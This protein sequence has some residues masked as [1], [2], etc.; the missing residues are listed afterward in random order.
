MPK[1]EQFFEHAN[2]AFHGL[3]TLDPNYFQ[4]SK[5]EK[6][7]V[8]KN[9]VLTCKD[10]VLYPFQLTLITAEVGS[11]YL[12]NKNPCKLS[13]R[14]SWKT[15]S[16]M[17][18]YHFNLV[19]IP[20][21][22]SVLEKKKRHKIGSWIVQSVLSDLNLSDVYRG[23]GDNL[24][25]LSQT[26]SYVAVSTCVIDATSGSDEFSLSFRS[27]PFAICGELLDEHILSILETKRTLTRV[28]FSNC[29]AL[30]D[31]SIQSVIRKCAPLEVPIP[32]LINL[33]RLYI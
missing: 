19:Y 10:I 21:Q 25:W 16:V 20:R 3:H 18:H 26:K 9:P 2:A 15:L 30:T 17:D 33:F 24:G 5:D 12:P 14:A 32:Q 27:N 23:G 7:T 29:C 28:D 11:D 31:H 6:N 8:E 1:E 13:L 4:I 22:S